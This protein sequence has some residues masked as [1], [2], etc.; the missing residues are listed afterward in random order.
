VEGEWL[1]WL[2]RLRRTPSLLPPS[3]PFE[4]QVCDP[5]VPAP[6][7]RRLRSRAENLPCDGRASLR[8]D[9]RN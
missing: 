2:A 4:T 9:W 7:C 8:A 3:I 5:A 1:D 6:D